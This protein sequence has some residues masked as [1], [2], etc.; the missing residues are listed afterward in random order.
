MAL[1]YIQNIKKSFN[2]K[3]IFISALA[4]A[5]CA[6]G[7]FN[8]NSSN[9]WLNHMRSYTTYPINY[10]DVEGYDT[11]EHLLETKEVI[12][13]TYKR[14]VEV[15]A[16]VGQRMVDSESLKIKKFSKSKIIASSDGVVS[17]T[18]DEIHIKNGQEFIP[19]GEVVIDG[20]HYMLIDA[21]GRGGILLVDEK[22]YITNNI[23]AI[24]KGNLLLS[25]IYAS[26]NPETM[27][28]KSTDSE[29]ID[30]SEKKENFAIIFNGL[31]NGFFELTYINYSKSASGEA[32]KY[33]YA[34]DAKYISVEGVKMEITGV[35]PDRIEYKLS[36]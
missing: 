4:L 23:N 6:C 16:N 36:D 34:K 22:G 18:A 5:V 15:S 19:L 25:K 17:N 28:I 32:R 14:N 27:V 12:T 3:K 20:K 11:S 1:V 9:Y 29:R 31:N 26:V 10:Y 33:T 24:Y 30:V 21:D 35:Y 8:R 7:A 2:M 13:H